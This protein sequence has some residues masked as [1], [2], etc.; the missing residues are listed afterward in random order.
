MATITDVKLGATHDLGRTA[1]RLQRI[2]NAAHSRDRQLESLNCISRL[3]SGPAQPYLETFNRIS[4]LASGPAQPY[5]ETFNRINRLRSKVI[6]DQRQLDRLV[7]AVT[8]PSA[9]PLL[10]LRR[11]S[12][13]LPAYIPARH[14]GSGPFPEDTEKEEEALVVISKSELHPYVL[15]YCEMEL[16]NGDYFHAVLEAIKSLLQRVRDLT[17]LKSDGVQLVEE[18]FAY[19]KRTPYIS[20]NKLVTSS[21]TNRQEGMI[22]ALRSLIFMYRNPLAHEPRSAWPL[23][24]I[25]AILVLSQISKYHYWIDSR[26]I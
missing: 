12:N 17:G 4:R 2:V 21:E 23:D 1:V 5:L 20:L 26:H 6:Q 9:S 18:A 10:D 7:D 3:A 8:F 24:D 16:S 13:V 19:K 14:L 25:E 11:Q 22:H 15:M